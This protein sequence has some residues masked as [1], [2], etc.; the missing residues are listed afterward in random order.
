MTFEAESIINSI[1]ELERKGL[2]YKGDNIYYKKN[3]SENITQILKEF[4][5]A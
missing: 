4:L 2:E 5:R 1:I 3:V